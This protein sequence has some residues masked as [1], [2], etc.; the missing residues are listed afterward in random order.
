M[1]NEQTELQKGKKVYGRWVGSLTMGLSLI[2]SGIIILFGLLF[3]NLVDLTFVFQL[4]PLFLIF[5]G[6]EILF[7]YFKSHGEKINYNF[8]SIFLCFIIIC[9][10][11]VLAV[12]YQA[13]QFYATQNLPYF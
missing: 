8:F 2:I 4:S 12:F 10:C 7:H 5:L 6:C 3:P 1:I 11:F 13:I 9:S